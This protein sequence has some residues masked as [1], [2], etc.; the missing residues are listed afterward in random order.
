[1]SKTLLPR[2]TECP[3]KPRSFAISYTSI[4]E[5]GE[6]VESVY[7]G[8]MY[9]GVP[10][11]EGQTHGGEITEGMEYSMTTRNQGTRRNAHRESD[12]CGTSNA[13]GRE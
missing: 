12:S 6:G 11:A 2:R 10:E 13:A 8:G 7:K 3:L 4:G 1:M 5:L 9:R